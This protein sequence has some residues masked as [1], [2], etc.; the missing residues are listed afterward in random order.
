ML[1]S[2]ASRCLLIIFPI[3]FLSLVQ[4]ESGYAQRSFGIHYT[5]PESI[6][7]FHN[8]LRYLKQTG[9]H[10]L[11]LEEV[12]DAGE[13]AAIEAAGLDVYVS[14]PVKFPT[15]WS[16]EKDRE[17][18][19]RR[20][21]RY[22]NFYRNYDNVKGIGLFR[23]GQTHSSRFRDFF[24]SLVGEIDRITDIPLYY[25]SSSAVDSEFSALFDFRIYLAAD[26]SDISGL[27]A[28]DRI[29]GIA[30]S[31][32]GRKF[33]IRMFQAILNQ[34]REIAE[35]PLFLEW[36]WFAYNLSESNLIEEVIHLYAA[37]AN[38]LFA[39]PGAQPEK[40]SSNWLILILLIIW[41]SFVIH[42]SLMPTYRKSLMRFFDNHTFLMNDVMSRHIRVGQSSTFILFQQGL[43]GGLFLLA[44]VKYT[45]SPLGFEALIFHLP[46][47]Y[48]YSPNYFVIFLT[49][50]FLFILFNAIC[51]GWL[52]LMNSGIRHLSQAAIFQLWPQH[53]NLFVVTLLIALIFSGAS[54]VFI[55]IVAVMFLIVLF[56]SFVY[57][58]ID[59]G[60]HTYTRY[61]YYPLTLVVYA[62]LML[63]FL[64]WVFLTT[65]FTEFWDLA[66]SL[67]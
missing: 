66:V 23:F 25:I 31:P 17:Q 51:T 52:Y 27:A 32:P 35:V 29:G 18:L 9:I 56:G 28:F 14:V 40:T 1:K 10:S 47:I 7:R 3:L 34:T 12:I 54:P 2:A 24:E 45:L 22:I 20:W 6:D 16:I 11:M 4:A 57:S 8:D 63:S 36:E 61:F 19:I 62:C 37:D 5:P 42:Y 30:Y 64:F 49:G 26:T 46:L 13:M 33:D 15:V 41:A 67:D 65:G 43:L 58:V 44:L 55:N 59:A 53:L 48:P 39:N 21:S 38:A 60:N 50:F